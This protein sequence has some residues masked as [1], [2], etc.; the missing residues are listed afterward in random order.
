M[1]SKKKKR[2]SHRKFLSVDKIPH[3]LTVG[4][5]SSGKSTL[6]NSLIGLDLFPSKNEACTAKQITYIGNTERKNFLYKTDLTVKPVLRKQLFSKNIEEWNKDSKIHKCLIEG[7]L[8]T[9]QKKSFMITD[10]PGPNNSADK[11]HFEVMKNAFENPAYT[12]IFYI[13]NATQLGTEDDCNLL[14]FVKRNCDVKKLIFIINKAD[15]IDNTEV[16]NLQLTSKTVRDYLE[17][18][19]IKDPSVYFVSALSA[20]LAKKKELGEE[21]TRKENKEYQKMC[22]YLENPISNSNFGVEVNKN[23]ELLASNNN[24]LW[25]FSGI[26]ALLKTI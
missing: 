11:S 24:Q 5:M 9:I 1:V 2:I 20:L 26:P 17:S 12:K 7:P 6:I 13:M 14:N 4:T 21:F 25:H 19:E 22:L 8:R 23:N 16:E 10:T 18:I 15:Q 3:Y